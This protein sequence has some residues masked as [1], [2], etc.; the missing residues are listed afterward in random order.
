MMEIDPKDLAK[1]IKELKEENLSLDAQMRF[2]KGEIQRIVDNNPDV[3]SHRQQIAQN[4]ADMNTN[5]GTIRGFEE[6]IALDKGKENSKEK[7]SKKKK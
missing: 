4:A 6:L 2:S 1:R 7:K 3:Q 5:T